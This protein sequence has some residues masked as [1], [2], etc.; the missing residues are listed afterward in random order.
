MKF[1]DYQKKAV[2]SVYASA[3]SGSKQSV[4]CSPVGSGKSVIMAELCR[5]ARR[6]IV[7]SPSLPL[8][9]QLVSNL[10][11]W[12]NEPIEVE[13]GDNR[14]S[15]VMWFRSRVRVTSR[16]SML[17][18]NRYAGRAYDGT[19]LVI[20]DECHVGITPRM[21]AML[22][23]YEQMG[24]HIV[25]LSATPYRGKG[26]P[27]PYWDRPCFSYSLL[28]AINDGWLV[29]P[30][31][32]LSEMKA[33]DL[34]LIDEVAHEWDKKQLAAVLTA[35]HAVQEIASLVLQTFNR[36]PSAVYCHCV[37]QAKLVAEVLTRYG[38][39]VSVVWGSQQKF[40]REANMEAFRSGESKI[41]CNVGVLAYGW[42]HPQ[43][44]NIYNA[45]PTQSLSRYE[46]RIGRGTRT[47]PGDVD[48][49]M[50]KE[51]RLASIAAGEKPEFF[52]YD[53]TDTSR[54]TQLVN[55]LDVLDAKTPENEERRERFM[56]A[57]ESGVDVIE[58]SKNQDAIDEQQ[59]LL[60]AAELKK[61]RSR[62][63]VGMTF[64]HES[65]DL[66]SAPTEKK[67]RG[68]RMLWGPYKGQT[69]RSMPTSYLQYVER[70]TKKESPFKKA[71][72]GELSDRTKKIRPQD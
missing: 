43:L 20:V 55:A 41:I 33:V 21:E 30:R 60:A 9:D 8:L 22:R 16:A 68:W 24:A 49:D 42:D 58:E 51:E 7:I 70:V 56:K 64:D 13:Q 62:L 11:V 23:Y 52:I 40:D 72:R 45:A 5:V 61:Q 28:E 15:S 35:E 50:T 63:I 6:P 44:R 4:I 29:R 48:A 36:M 57:A 19:S 27:L 53:L 1:R 25:G 67:E 31:A 14:A 37:L 2:Q 65:R 71:V 46:Q 47:M 54:A 59:R 18:R 34:S 38:H 69:L 17:S 3:R 66:F 39:K 10:G 32:F 12:L 26:K